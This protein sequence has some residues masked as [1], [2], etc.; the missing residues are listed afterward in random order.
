MLIDFMSSLLSTF[1]TFFF[2]LVFTGGKKTSKTQNPF[3]WCI[4][5]LN[6]PEHILSLH[7]AWSLYAVTSPLRLV[8]FQNSASGPFFFLN[9]LRIQ[10]S[11]QVLWV[12]FLLN[13]DN[14]ISK[15]P[16]TANCPCA[17]AC[18]KKHIQTTPF[19]LRK[20]RVY[21]AKTLE[22]FLQFWCFTIFR[23]IASLSILT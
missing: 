18:F 9:V 3:N 6:F 15:S 7:K 4:K 17:K 21:D 12:G 8:Q 13:W 2:F 16:L 14:C 20:L 5:T 19:P 23:P 11:P 1:L 10:R 22:I